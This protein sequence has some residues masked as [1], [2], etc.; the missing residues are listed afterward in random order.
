MNTPTF[1][2][3]YRIDRLHN[4]SVIKIEIYDGHH[5]LTFFEL[6]H[7]FKNGYPVKIA[8]MLR[9]TFKL[10]V[11]HG[12][13][14]EALHRFL[15]R[16]QVFITGTDIPLGELLELGWKIEEYP[17]K[18]GVSGKEAK[19]ALLEDAKQKSVHL[20]ASNAIFDPAM[21]STRGCGLLGLISLLK[22]NNIDTRLYVD[23]SIFRKLTAEGMFD[24]RSYLN[25]L[26]NDHGP[27]RFITESPHG[28][29]VDPILLDW[30]DRTGGHAISRDSY[31]DHERDFP[32]LLFSAAAGKPRLHKFV[33]DGVNVGVPDFGLY[34]PI[35]SAF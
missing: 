32:T 15:E 27:T 26:L 21:V 22:N 8:A 12:M 6:N 31:D 11:A 4:S 19:A 1:N 20:D 3:Y 28:K 18:Y 24:V 23:Y 30:A 9:R 17:I 10:L 14:N 5:W 2:F 25:E 13:S 7:A 33:C 29:P 35:P 34:G 16:K